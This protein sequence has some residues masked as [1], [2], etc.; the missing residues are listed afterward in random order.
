MT[1]CQRD[2]AKRRKHR[3]ATHTKVVAGVK[4]RVSGSADD[5]LQMCCAT[6]DFTVPTVSTT[7]ASFPKTG[8]SVPAS[9]QLLSV[10]QH[11]QPSFFTSVSRQVTPQE[12]LL[13]FATTSTRGA[14]FDLSPFAFRFTS[15]TIHTVQKRGDYEVK[16][17]ELITDEQMITAF[18]TSVS[19]PNE[20][21]EASVFTQW[22]RTGDVQQLVSDNKSAAVKRG[23]NPPDF[24][25]SGESQ[26]AVEVSTFV[27]ERKKIYDKAPAFP[28]AYTSILRRDKADAPFHAAVK[29]QN[30]PD[31]SMVRPHFENVVDLDNDYYKTMEPVISK[32][33]AH[34]KE[35]AQ[36]YDHAVILI[37]DSLSEFE[38]TLERRLPRLREYLESLHPL[39]SVEVVVLNTS[40]G[41]AGKAYRL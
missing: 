16:L 30:L 26:I 5:P 31:N 28:G 13:G 33:I 27:T 11:I 23:G 17:S 32:K 38:P 14:R 1:Q 34:A 40:S 36:L 37:D 18:V 3:E 4:E 15:G 21:E 6:G 2:E 39:P 19:A 10:R 9:L 20:R 29:G 24:L 12:H 35:Y 25:I 8:R 7:H 41:R 22:L